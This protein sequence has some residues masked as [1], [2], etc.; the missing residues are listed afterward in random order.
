MDRPELRQYPRQRVNLSALVVQPSAATPTAVIDLSEG[1]GALEW[2]LPAGIV[3]GEAVSL[4][5]LLPGGQGLEI[6]GRV[7]RIHQGR[8]GIEFRAGQRDLVRQLL[9]ETASVD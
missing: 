9:A 2:N 4:R 6:A 1:G 8:A 7:V 5:F 3:V